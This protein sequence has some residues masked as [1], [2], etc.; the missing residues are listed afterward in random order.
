MANFFLKNL[1]LLL[2]LLEFNRIE[3][4]VLSVIAQQILSIVQAVRSGLKKFM[5]EGTELPLNPSC[6]VCIT[7]N[8]T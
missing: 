4:E 6:Y 3:L 2:K 7:V 8:Y 5:F 1:K